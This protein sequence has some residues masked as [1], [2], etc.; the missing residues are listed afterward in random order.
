MASAR[1]KRALIRFEKAVR[2]VSWKGAQPPETHA[3][4]DR[5][6]TQAKSALLY[7]IDKETG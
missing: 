2:A 7:L 4:I 6:Y 1:I 5:E 3:S